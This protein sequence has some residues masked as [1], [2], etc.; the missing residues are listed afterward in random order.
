L[1]VMADK[2]GVARK[3]Y[4][5]APSGDHYDIAMSKRE[6][7]IE[8]GAKPITCKQLAMMCRNRRMHGVLGEP[9]PN[10]A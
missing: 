1:H 6:L 10:Y 2:I 3:W 9:D 8:Y 7:A 4:Q 5:V